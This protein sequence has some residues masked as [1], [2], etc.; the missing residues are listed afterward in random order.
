MTAPAF[1][2]LGPV[3]GATRQRWKQA[4]LVVLDG[5][6]VDVAPWSLERVVCVGRVADRTALGDALEAASRGASLAVVVADELADDLFDDA[7]R[8]GLEPV[9]PVAPAEEANDREDWMAL[10]EALAEGATV[11]QAARACHLSLRSAYRRIDEARRVLGVASTTAA[12][13]AWQ[14]RK[15]QAPAS[16]GSV[17]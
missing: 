9:T 4:G 11:A 15:A 10:L 5:F 12:V 6:A 2:H 3:D 8:L 17:S 1:L 13:V 7:L 16:G 14:T